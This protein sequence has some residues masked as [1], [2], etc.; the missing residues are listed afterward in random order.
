MSLRA[1]KLSYIPQ[2]DGKMQVDPS[3]NIEHN[4]DHYKCLCRIRKS[5]PNSSSLACIPYPNNNYGPIFWEFL[6]RVAFSNRYTL[7]EE[8]MKDTMKLMDNIMTLFPC[9]ICSD[10]YKEYL[11]CRKAPAEYL[12]REANRTLILNYGLFEWTWTI[13]NKAEQ[14]SVWIRRCVS[15]IFTSRGMFVVASG[16]FNVCSCTP[17]LV[18]RLTH[19]TRGGERHHRSIVFTCFVKPA[20]G[21]ST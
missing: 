10:A 20:L 11:T 21:L 14:T 4:M 3:P 13:H 12:A 15:Q 6:H 17:G 8:K 2:L 1:H 18:C 16:H 5:N 7:L 9:H 19:K